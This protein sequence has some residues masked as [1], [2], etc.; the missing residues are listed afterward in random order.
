MRLRP[1][2]SRRFVAGL[3]A[4]G[5]LALA[6]TALAAPFA[7]TGGLIEGDGTTAPSAAP[8]E[9]YCLWAASGDVIDLRG[10]RTVP[11]DLVMYFYRGVTEDDTV[12]LTQ[13]AFRDD[14]EPPPPGVG[15]PFGDPHL[16]NFAISQTGRYTVRMRRFLDAPHGGW[17]LHHSGIGQSTQADLSDARDDVGALVLTGNQAILRRDTVYNNFLANSIADANTD[18]CGLGDVTAARQARQGFNYLRTPNAEL[19]AASV[20]IRADIYDA[21]ERMADTRFAEVDA[22]GDAPQN[23]LD[24]AAGHIALAAGNAGTDAG[25]VQLIKAIDILKGETPQIP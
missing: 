19:A 6:A 2:R 24:Q 5:A 8:N 25:L 18:S 22:R 23:L 1:K 17:V 3:V 14:E 12:G 9:N 13:L 7:Y 21:V 4:I 15:G 11:E 20:G 10:E 16:E